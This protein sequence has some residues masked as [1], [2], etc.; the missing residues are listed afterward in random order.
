MLCNRTLEALDDL[1]TGG[2]VGPD[3][4]TVVLRT[5]LVGECR[6]ADQVAEHHRELPTF[7]VG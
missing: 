7:A 3:D 5:E 2:L 4:L 6:G 1:G